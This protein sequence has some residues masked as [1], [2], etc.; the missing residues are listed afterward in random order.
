MSCDFSFILR[1]GPKN[2]GDPV[3]YFIFNY[4]FYKKDCKDYP[5]CGENQIEIIKTF[6]TEA[7]AQKIGSVKNKILEDYS[8]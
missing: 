1:N 3:T 8:R 5:N 7:I 2:S 6:G 4:I